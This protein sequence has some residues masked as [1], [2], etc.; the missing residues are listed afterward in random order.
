MDDDAKLLT[1][2]MLQAEVFCAQLAVKR[3]T[4]ADFE[5]SSQTAL[6]INQC[7]AALS[8]LQ[9]IYEADE[10]GARH[11]PTLAAFRRLVMSLMWAAFYAGSSVN[12]RLY[13]KLM[14]I[15]SGFTFLLIKHVKSASKG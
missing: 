10:L 5:A 6:R 11:P 15:E 9:S 8:E 13:R 3:Q 4:M 14:Q 12:H 1:E 7:H 2:M